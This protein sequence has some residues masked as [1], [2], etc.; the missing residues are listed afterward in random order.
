[1]D[2]FNKLN[3]MAKAACIVAVVMVLTGTLVLL[4]AEK[5]ERGFLGVSL[6]RLGDAEREKLG[7]THGVLVIAVDK[8]SGAAK[9]GIQKDDVI[10]S[11]NGE[12]IR[13]PQS[14]AEVVGEMAPGSA[15]KI[16]LWRGG[17]AQEVKAVLG[18]VERPKRLAWHGAP[19]PKFIR[20]GP[21]L[22]INLL[23]LDADLAA[24][25]GVKPG[26]GVLITGVEKDTPAAKA[27]LKA[28]DVIVQMVDKPIKSSEDIHE[29]LAALKKGDSVVITVV[30]HGKKEALKAE[31]DF[32]HRHNRIMR[33]FSGGKDI[34]IEHLEL[35]ELNIEIPDIDFA[36]PCPP[37]PPLAAEVLR[38]VHEKLDNVRVKVGSGL[39]KIY[40][41]NWI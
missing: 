12:K 16:G 17:K 40:E 33:I 13:D 39:K 7:V 41:N 31:P 24:Y 34:E 14:L 15:M 20:S 9:A 19:L 21:Y 11:A 32:Q 37:E 3:G 30:R 29:A 8:E 10:Q 5:T 36:P 6:Q 26:E 18:K 27:G 1:M 4:A 22:G 25:F 2:K 38:H 35:P 23:E 28:G